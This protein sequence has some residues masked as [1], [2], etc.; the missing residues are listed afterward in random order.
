MTIIPIFHSSNEVIR[1]PLAG[2][3][4][5]L[6][7]RGLV[8][9]A[10]NK[11]WI[12]SHNHIYGVFQFNLVLTRKLFCLRSRP[13]WLPRF[14]P[15]TCSSGQR[16][17]SRHSCRKWNKK[18]LWV[19]LRKEISNTLNTLL[20]VISRGILSTGDS[21]LWKIHVDFNCNPSPETR[22]RCMPAR[23]KVKLWH[24]LYVRIPVLENHPQETTC[25]KESYK[26]YDNSTENFL[27][28]ALTFRDS[29]NSRR[30]PFGGPG[31]WS[32]CRWCKWKSPK[33]PLRKCSL[34]PSRRRPNLV[35]RPDQTTGDRSWDP[36]EKKKGLRKKV[37][38]AS[39][40]WR[41]GLPA[42]MVWVL[43]AQYYIHYI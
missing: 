9:F 14:L 19:S 39:A 11:H 43:S 32:Q 30:E 15:G 33:C 41:R 4:S 26:G 6:S 24:L 35:F 5:Q 8:L 27:I 22:P 20:E 2:K 34:R 25:S 1:G 31:W 17:Q 21:V 3:F 16:I 42:K 38:Y 28:M 36:A 40:N 13:W 12:R 23:K 10:G 29:S 37:W 18:Y 7:W